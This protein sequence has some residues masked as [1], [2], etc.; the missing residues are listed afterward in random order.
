MPRT[1][2]RWSSRNTTQRHDHR[3]ERTGR[4]EVPL[5]AAVPDERRSA[6]TVITAAPAPAPRK[7]SAT[8]RSFQTHRNWKIAKAAS[9]GTDSGSTIRSEHLEVRR[10]VDR[11]RLEQVA[12]AAG[13]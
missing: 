2:Y 8:S 3:Q 12:R 10:A 1:K 4:Q 11:G 7:T 5:L 13:R 9:A 6:R